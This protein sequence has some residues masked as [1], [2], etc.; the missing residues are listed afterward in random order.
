MKS[1]K[2]IRAEHKKAC[3]EIA[4][5]EEK[6]RKAGCD[7]GPLPKDMN[8]YHQLHTIKETLEWVDI[9]LIKTNAKPSDPNY[10]KAL[11][12]MGHSFYDLGP[13]DATLTRP[14]R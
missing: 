4:V 14:R 6:G 8:Q 13:V 5:L 1:R 9:G 7:G 10:L 3:D 11:Q 12:D 2:A